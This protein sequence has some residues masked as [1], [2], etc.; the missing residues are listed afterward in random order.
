MVAEEPEEIREAEEEASAPVMSKCLFDLS[1]ANCLL[2]HRPKQPIHVHLLR[3]FYTHIYEPPA[4]FSLCF[5]VACLLPL[6]YFSWCQFMLSV[7]SLAFLFTL[8]YKSFVAESISCLDLP[9]MME[10][11]QWKM[12]HC[13]IPRPISFLIFIQWVKIQCLVFN[14]LS[15]DDF[16]LKQDLM[17][18]IL[19]YLSSFGRVAA[20][21]C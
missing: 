21:W 5:C 20:M 2:V 19:L 8:H 11:W 1:V 9:W 16:L 3:F 17:F 13:H 18:Y 15:F 6:D 10:C 14:A 12:T 7:H 4:C